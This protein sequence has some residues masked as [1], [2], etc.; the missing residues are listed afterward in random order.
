MEEIS[1]TTLSTYV[2]A[3]SSFMAPICATIHLWLYNSLILYFSLIIATNL[4]KLCAKST[5]SLF[6]FIAQVTDAYTWLL[7]IYQNCVPKVLLACSL[8]LHKLQML[9]RMF[10]QAL[11]N[12]SESSCIIVN[13]FENLLV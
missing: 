13:T 9:I 2:P 10:L 3:I 12:K 5:F 8:L 4:P 11:V 6:P 1:T 7:L